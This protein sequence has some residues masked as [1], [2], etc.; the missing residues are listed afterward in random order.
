MMA[1]LVFA[2]LRGLYNYYEYHC[3]VR[4]AFAPLRGLYNSVE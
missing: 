4:F 2:P 1:M 3:K